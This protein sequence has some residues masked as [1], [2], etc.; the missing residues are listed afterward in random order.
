MGYCPP[1]LQKNHRGD[2]KVMKTEGEGKEESEEIKESPRG[3]GEREIDGT[4][5]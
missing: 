4:K 3:K 2:E 1:C 5:T